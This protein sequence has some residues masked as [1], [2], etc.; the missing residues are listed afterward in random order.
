MKRK[1][2]IVPICTLIAILGSSA[3]ISVA[4][5]SNS[6]RL[7]IEGIDIALKAGEN[8]FISTKDEKEFYKDHLTY[9]DLIKVPYFE[10]VSSM[11]SSKWMES[12]AKMPSF[13]VGYDAYNNKII[14]KD[15]LTYIEP[16]EEKATD[17]FY[18]Q[19]LF[20]YSDSNY[21]ALIDTTNTFFIANEST[22]RQT[23]KLMAKDTGRDEEEIYNELKADLDEITN[24]K[25]INPH[26]IQSGLRSVNFHRDHPDIYKIIDDMCLD[27][28]LKGKG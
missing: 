19:E 22:N 3:T 2:I 11:M 15:S 27:Y 14:N 4:W 8:L 26:D 25:A 17:G 13:Y 10:P 7:K 21:W 6:D 9:N 16:M 28:D 5:F 18:S 12:K 24:K 23:A 20:L 1:F